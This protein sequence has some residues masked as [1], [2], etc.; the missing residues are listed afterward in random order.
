[1]NAEPDKCDELRWVDPC[2]LPS[3]TTP[4]VRRAIQ[5]MEK[6]IVFAELGKDFLIANGV[7]TLDP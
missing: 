7:Y 5:D 1:M 4:H 3:N 6:G 2:D